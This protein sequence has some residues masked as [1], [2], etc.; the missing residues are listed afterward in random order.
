VR[1]TFWV[2]I[3]AMV[4]PAVACAQQAPWVEVFGGY[5]YGLVRGYADD[6]LV[7]GSG[8]AAFGSFGS[9][10]WIGSAAFNAT[11]LLG[12]VGDVSDLDT[13]LT[14]HGVTLT[15]HAHTY[16]IGPRIY[17]RTERW[18]VFA[19]VM[20][21]EAHASAGVSSPEMITPGGFVATKIAAAAG[22][23][24][25]YTIYRRGLHFNRSGQELA[26]RI[27]QVDWLMTNFADGHQNNFRISTGLVFRF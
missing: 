11:K 9:K 22:G 6:Q 27:V 12:V 13:D 16:L 7:P 23:G 19:H 20:I 26:A 18:E 1:K 25:D 14:S 10:G 5:A 4:V 17:Y 21:G 8:P 3:M 24:M 15:M 2:I